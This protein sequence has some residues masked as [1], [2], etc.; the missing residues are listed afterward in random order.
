MVPY[1][2]DRIA[3]DHL[4]EDRHYYT[5]LD[6]A[7]LAFW[8]GFIKQAS[9]TQAAENLAAKVSHTLNY[10]KI[11]AVAHKAEA[12]APSLNYAKMNAVTPR[13]AAPKTLDY[14]KMA[15]PAPA[16]PRWK[17]R[18]Q[19]NAAP[20]AAPA[21]AAHRGSWSPEMRQKIISGNG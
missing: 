14:S 9:M 12:A 19:A 8:R 10:G 16:Q 21:A 7:K 11:N 5:H 15:P 2:A 6:E 18:M 17:T 1:V 3:K 4:E 13:A 20:A